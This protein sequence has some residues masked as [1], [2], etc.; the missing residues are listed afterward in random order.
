MLP[1]TARRDLSLYKLHGMGN[2]FLVLID[3]EGLVGFDS[4]LARAL[5]QRRTGVGADGLIRARRSRDGFAMELLNAD[6]SAA[7]TSGNGLRCLALALVLSGEAVPPPE[8]PAGV[9][10]STEVGLRRAQVGPIAP[11]GSS[12]VRVSMGQ[13]GL[14]QETKV[15]GHRAQLVDMGNPHVVVLV[16][17]PDTI[18]LEAEG[19]AEELRHAGGINV[20]FA[21]PAGPH[22]VRLRTWE[23]GAGATLACGSGSC[24]TATAL[25]AWG[26]VEGPVEVV[27]PGGSVEVSWESDEEIFLAGPAQLIAA[28]DVGS[29]PALSD[30]G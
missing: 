11:D 27:N 6:G 24:A 14:G 21:A 5:C 10:I 3:P 30:R 13:V 19:R 12:P 17:D 22:R 28:L 29:V 7:E 23:R 15:A 20:N 18:E 2:D 25:A 8:G 16:E 9:L 4:A 26:L 1:V